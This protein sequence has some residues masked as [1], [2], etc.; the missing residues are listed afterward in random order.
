MSSLSATSIGRLAVFSAVI[1]QAIGKVAFGTWLADFPSA[2]FVLISFT[3]TATFFLSLS[4]KG[5]GEL[6]WGPVALL[7][8]STALTFLCFFYALKLIEPSIVGAV[9]IGIGP[10]LAVVITLILSGVRP[11]KLRILVCVGV[12]AGCGVLAV[13]AQKG[14]GL[15][16]EGGNAWYGLSAS[17][18]AG[19]GAVLITMASKS[20]I[21]RGWK[22]GAVLAHRFY[23]IL[24]L[25]LILAFSSDLSTIEW[26]GTLLILLVFVSLVGV[27]VPLYLLQM[28]VG[29]CDPYTVMVTMAALPVITFVLEGFSPV[30]SWSWMT[31]LGLL[32]V[33]AFLLLDVFAKKS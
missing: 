33:S 10:V 29:R 4:R 18:A 16:V 30:Y 14:T 21:G 22:F 7:N 24:P 19:L 25:S 32:I 1:L 12:L 2:L 11:T 27:L 20:L 31:G 5:V 9:E 3:L 13:A 6:A 26:S 17:A 28:G 8:I 15:A 23:L